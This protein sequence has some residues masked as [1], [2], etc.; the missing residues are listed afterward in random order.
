MGKDST[1]KDLQE[2]L[3]AQKATP[4]LINSYMKQFFL[5]IFENLNQIVKNLL[6]IVNLINSFYF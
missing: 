2:H 6:I 4:V 3:V 1:K 5:D